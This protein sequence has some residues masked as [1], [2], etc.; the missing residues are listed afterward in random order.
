MMVK[1]RS[2]AHTTI[3]RP[4][5]RSRRVLTLVSA[6]TGLLLIAGPAFA[7]FCYI[8]TR[9]DQGNQGAAKSQAWVSVE[10]ILVEELGLCEEG[11]DFFEAAYLAPRGLTTATLLHEKALLAAPHFGTPKMSDGKG[12]DHLFNS[13]Q[14]FA[15][16]DE[17]IGGAFAVCFGE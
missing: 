6:V 5:V 3:R 2:T 9:S 4:G 10:H 16:L 1:G 14:D 13:E 12:V 8:P 11:V 15:D 7:H 17:A